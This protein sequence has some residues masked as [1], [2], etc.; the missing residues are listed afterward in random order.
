[1]GSYRPLDD[2]QEFLGP[3]QFRKQL[4]FFQKVARV[5]A[6]T[7]AAQ[8][9]RMFEVQHLV[10]KDVFHDKAGHS[11]VIEYA[12]DDDGVVGRV[13]MAEPVA[14]LISAPGKLRTTHQ[15]VKETPVQVVKHRFQIKIM[16]AR[17][18]NMLASAH[19]AH[20]SRLGSHVMARDVAAVAHGIGSA[21]RLAIKF[22]QQDME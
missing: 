22:C 21:D 19:V 8:L 10:E 15:T 20:Q 3:L 7:A 4:F 12:A 14:R 18:M 17:G 6:T 16:A 2:L 11:S 1:M 9:D 5:D 13:V